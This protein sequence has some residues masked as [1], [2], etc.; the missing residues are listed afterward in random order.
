MTNRSLEG[1]SLLSDPAGIEEQAAEWL[2]R[3]FDASGWTAQ[4]QRE[5]DVWLVASSAHQL[6]YWRLEAAW[7]RANRLNALRKSPIDQAEPRG[8]IFRALTQIALALVLMG[9][10]LGGAMLFFSRQHSVTYQTGIGGHKV[11]ALSDGSRIELNTD[12][13]L[14]VS[15]GADQRQIW[16]EKGEA[17]FRV[18]HDP[19]RQFVVIAGDS[20]IVDIGTAFVVRRDVR[21]LEVALI[22][23]RAEIEAAKKDAGPRSIL[24]KAGDVA[25]ARDGAVT[26]LQKTPAAIADSLG[27]R[28]G[29]LIFSDTPLARVADEFNRYNARKLVVLGKDV[30]NLG[31]GGHFQADN[32]ETFARVAEGVLGLH[33]VSHGDEIVISR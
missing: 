33:V 30:R 1:E 16:L 6:A 32:A 15:D 12:T 22:E 29:L 23:G 26:L 24:L 2:I 14:R 4:A 20:R 8:R 13:M 5:L 3:R 19:A 10:G 27:W 11:F 18:K 17:Y 25:V 7:S 31:V 28:R 21:R 9:A